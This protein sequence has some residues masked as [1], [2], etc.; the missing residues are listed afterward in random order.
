MKLLKLKE[1]FAYVG[2]FLLENYLP[3]PHFGVTIGSNVAWDF[4]NCA[5]F[6]LPSGATIGGSAVVALATITSSSANALTTG[7]NGATNP[8]FNVDNSTGSLAAGLN[9]K[10][11]IA[12]GT[13]AV[14]VIS[15]GSNANLSVDAKGS[16]VIN[17]GGTSTGLLALGRGGHIVTID[18][19]LLTDLG[20]N[21]NSTPTAAQLL[22]GYLTQASTTGAGTV[23]L[24]TGTLLSTAVT[25]VTVGDTFDCWLANTGNQTL[26]I[27]GAV[28][29]TVIGTA[30]L[31]TL[32]NAIMTFYNTGSN[33]WNVY[34]YVS[35]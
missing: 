10:G 34:C 7:P 21:Q 33:T 26:T 12:A 5:T 14:S 25:G 23:T 13:V 35:A 28:G 30:A 18:N 17:I 19:D 8:G 15:S 24:C 3:I 31:P 1:R 16:G 32:K 11:A 4:T 6:A 27:T 2:Q 9:V 29:T 20:T 22:G